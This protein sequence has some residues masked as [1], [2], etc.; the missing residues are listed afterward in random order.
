MQ[1]INLILSLSKASPEAPFKLQF[2]Y[3]NSIELETI[4]LPD[5]FIW[6]PEMVYDKKPLAV[7]DNNFY[8]ILKHLL[9]SIESYPY[10]WPLES[11][12]LD[13]YGYDLYNEG[14][15]FSFS[16]TALKV[17]QQA[18]NY[19]ASEA[20]AQPYTQPEFV[21]APHLTKLAL[22]LQK[23]SVLSELS[24]QIQSVQPVRLASLVYES[25]LSNYTTPV[26]LNLEKLQVTQT[27]N[28]LHILF[29]ESIL[30]RRFTFVLAQDN[31][32]SNVGLN[33]L[34]ITNTEELS[35]QDYETIAKWIERGVVLNGK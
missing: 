26:R 4:Y 7:V 15:I 1:Y 31:L 9:K 18:L 12:K 33:E 14:N 13:L 24:F 5:G 30:V 27:N 8:E 16:P 35:T 3:L 28:V 10:V 32:L 25:D 19:T 17:V 6:L 20:L 21:T 23:P 29:G 11:Q 2:K 34:P 22:T